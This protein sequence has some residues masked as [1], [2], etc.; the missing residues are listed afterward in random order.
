MK[1]SEFVFLFLFVLLGVQGLAF[2]T[3]S[4]NE[5]GTFKFEDSDS[6]RSFLTNPEI[7]LELG[8]LGALLPSVNSFSFL[9]K[10]RIDSQ[11]LGTVNSD[12][13]EIILTHI[14]SGVNDSF[15]L[16]V[17]KILDFLHPYLFF[18]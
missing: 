16:S 13:R 5:T 2:D 8:H 6:T 7:K 12:L 1:K 3:F 17:S 9:S 4:K 10:N 15:S 11:N 18:Y 14:S